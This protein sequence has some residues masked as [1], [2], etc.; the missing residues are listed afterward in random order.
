[1]VAMLVILDMGA[2]AISE[3]DPQ[4]TVVVV[5][6]FVLLMLAA[7]LFTLLSG[8][9]RFVRQLHHKHFRFFLCHQKNAAGSM[10]R[11]LKMKLEQSLPG[12]KTFIDCDEPW[13]IGGCRIRLLWQILSR[14]LQSGVFNFQLYT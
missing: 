9:Y 13:Q 6:F 12:T 7:V 3:E 14:L 8:L 10:A 4:T 11:L 5:M 2:T 1:M